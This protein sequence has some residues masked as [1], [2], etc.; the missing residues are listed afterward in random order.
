MQV[1]EGQDEGP[2][3][4]KTFE[5]P[6]GELEEPGTAVGLGAVPVHLTELGQQPGQLALLPGDG[7]VELVAE[8]AAQGAQGGRDRVIRQGVGAGFDTAAPG[9]DSPVR[10][11]TAEKLLD[12]PG[13]AD[14]G[15]APH[16]EGTGLSGIRPGQGLAEDG[17]F[18]VAAYEDRA[19]VTAFHKIEHRMPSHAARA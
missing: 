15:L 18:G 2:V 14:A 17:Q 11:S 3:R 19:Y 5:E 1:F 13:L 12:Q 10:G 4:G 6:D 16:E 9:D 7:R 8:L